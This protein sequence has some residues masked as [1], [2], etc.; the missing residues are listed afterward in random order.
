MPNHIFNKTVLIGPSEVLKKVEE[1]LLVDTIIR[2][3]WESKVAALVERE[4]FFL[5]DPSESIKGTMAHRAIELEQVGSYKSA[6]NVGF[7][8]GLGKPMPDSL[9]ISEGSSGTLGMTLLATDEQMQRMQKGRRFHIGADLERAWEGYKKIAV[10]KNIS[11]ASKY[12]KE[13]LIELV[14]KVD[15]EVLKLGRQYL[16]NLEQHGYTS[17]YEWS[18]ANWGT[19]WDAYDVQ[20]WRGGANKSELQ[21]VYSTAWSP[22]ISGLAHIVE[23]YGVAVVTG[24]HD[25]GG[26]FSGSSILLPKGWVIDKE[27]YSELEGVNLDEKGAIKQVEECTFSDREGRLSGVVS[28]VNEAKKIV[29]ELM[30]EQ[31]L[32]NANTLTVEQKAVT[33]IKRLWARKVKKQEPL[34]SGWVD[35][36]FKGNNALSEHGNTWFVLSSLNAIDGLSDSYVKSLWEYLDEKNYVAI[37]Q[38]MGVLGMSVRQVWQQNGWIAGIDIAQR[39]IEKTSQSQAQEYVQRALFGALLT[40]RWMVVRQLEPLVNSNMLPESVNQNWIDWANGSFYELGKFVDCPPVLR[41]QILENIVE[42]KNGTTRPDTMAREA[43]EE[44]KSLLEFKKIEKNIELVKE[45]STKKKSLGL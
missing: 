9:N 22:P 15:P 42:N 30:L 38:C 4:S 41:E 18:I 37:D 35:E 29:K 40:N 43:Y 10:D 3:S 7:S 13:N 27:K 8:L 44:V 23:R 21:I 33:K 19:K 45:H 32:L 11:Y 1:Q 12:S 31:T 24:Y 20:D 39:K 16:E 26:N 5:E 6:S 25:E 36:V 14:K 17:W 2:S 34:E 28:D